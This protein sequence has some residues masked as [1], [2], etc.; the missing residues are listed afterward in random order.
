MILIDPEIK[1]IFRRRRLNFAMNK[2]KEHEL[3]V[4]VALQVG[5]C[6]NSRYPLRVNRTYR[7]MGGPIKDI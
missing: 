4:E 1:I 3:I 2:E 5:H 7:T 6:H